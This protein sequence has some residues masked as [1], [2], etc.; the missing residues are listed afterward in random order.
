MKVLW[1]AS[2]YPNPK[3]PSNG[4]F[5]QRHARAVAETN[6]V[7]VLNVE[8]APQSITGGKILDIK[9]EQGRLTERTILYRQYS[10]GMLGRLRSTLRYFRVNRRAV[11]EYIETHGIP[12]MIHVHIPLR[13]GIVAWYLR[14]RYGV[15]FVVTEH[16]GGI[17]VP[18]EAAFRSRSFLFRFLY[19]KVLRTAD[20][21]S[22]V[23][24]HLANA[25]QHMVPSKRIEVIPNVVDC[26]LFYPADHKP[27]QFAFVHASGMDENKNVAEILRSFS[28]IHKR[29]PTVLL[30]LAGSDTPTL[31]SLVQSLGLESGVVV[32]GI[33]TQHELADLFRRSSA[34]VLFSRYETF[35]CVTAEAHACGLPVISSDIPA[36]RELITEERFGLLV[37]DQDPQGLEG[38]MQ[39][40][41]ESNPDPDLTVAAATREKFDFPVVGKKFTDWYNEV[42]NQTLD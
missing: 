27:P 29:Y 12:D 34:F 39:K 24:R 31:R 22:A 6:E 35:S 23:S 3:S 33:L 19:K 1:L 4:D 11:E 5:I 38:A 10:S 14:K 37:E 8:P 42:L 15:P 20:S 16:W 25:L 18:G 2:W 40:L 7:Y 17:I 30:H 41:I 9:N 36:L 32:H 13:A 21:I 26:S 28:T